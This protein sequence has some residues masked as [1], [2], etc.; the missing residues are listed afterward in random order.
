MRVSF[1]RFTVSDQLPVRA[2]EVAQVAHLRG[3]PDQTC[4][5]IATCAGV[6]R[7]E[8][9]VV[10]WI[11]AYVPDTSPDHCSH[12]KKPLGRIGEDAIAVLSGR[13]HVWLHHGCHP[14]W[15]RD[16]RAKAEQA[17]RMTNIDSQSIVTAER[18][19]RD[20]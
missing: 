13:G 4:A 2:A 1:K 16:L 19:E 8:A 7:R 3:T 12:C 14:G 10:R 18:Q 9:A 20:Q 5:G 17:I 15:R 11:N 6:N